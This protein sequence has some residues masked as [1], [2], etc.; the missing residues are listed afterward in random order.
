[1]C[2]I[3]CMSGITPETNAKAVALVKAIAPLMSTANRDGLGYT[4]IDSEGAMFGERWFINSA[5]FTKPKEAPSV[6]PFGMLERLEGAIDVES[7]GSTSI[8]EDEYN[9]F[10][11]VDLTKMTAVTL[12]TRWATSEK[13]FKN[14]HPFV[15]TNMDTS[16]IHNGVIRNVSDFNLELSTCDSESILISYLRN[17]VNLDPESVQSMANELTGYYACGVFSRDADGNRILDIFKANGASLSGVFVKELGVYVYSTQESDIK[18]ACEKVG[19]TPG[20]TFKLKAGFL[21]RFDPYTGMLKHK[22]AFAEGKEWHYTSSYTG[23][24]YKS[25]Y[26]GRGGR[27]GSNA[28]NVLGPVQKHEPSKI[29]VLRPHKKQLSNEMIAFLKLPPKSRLFTSSECLAFAREHDL[30]VGEG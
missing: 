7:S 30:L 23:N 9:N 14:V 29:S 1:M 22:E 16:L 19:L 25:D 18:D 8:K 21:L 17:M 26:S 4:A 5:A 10:G 15:N 12:H 27:N 6:D 13:G 3:F 11:E 20:I 24:N 2:K 28:T